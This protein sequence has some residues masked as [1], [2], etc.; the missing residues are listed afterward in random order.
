MPWAHKLDQMQP[1]HVMEMLA[2]AKA[3]AAQGRDIVRLEVGEPDFA[4][5]Q[6]VLEAAQRALAVDKTRYTNA[7]GLP[8]LRARIARWYGET[9]HVDL[10]PDRVALTPGTS[11]GFQLAFGLLL[12]PSDRIA[13]TDPGYPCY[14]NMIRFQ[15]G[16]PVTVAVGPEHGYHFT[17]DL[18]KPHLAEGLAGALVTSPS[19]PTGTLIDPDA[20]EA[21]AAELDAAGAALISDEIYH[22]LTYGEAARTALSFSPNALVINGFSK[23]FAMTGWRLGWLIAPP[24]AMRYV[25]ILSQNLFISAPTLSQYAALAVFDCQD[26][27]NAQAARYDLARRDLLARLPSL[28]FAVGPEPRGAFYV[29]ADAREA[30]AR[31]GAP[32][33]Q[34]L[35]VRLLEEAGVA[36]TPGIDFGPSGAG[37][38]VRF[39][40]AGGGER[41]AEG[42]NRLAGLLGGSDSAPSDRAS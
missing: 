19:N 35:C 31:L 22:G 21:V 33:A 36:I 13:I 30:M 26:E 7:L 42:L 16:E 27:L 8:E 39:S 37:D 14:P 9:Y 28:G 6:P 20:F 12:D 17:A 34:T 15:G 38:H 1:F 5:P 3:L 40:Y 24:E 41:V 32:D 29:Y 23:Y 25:E 4:T 2:R 11:G 10:D 18:L